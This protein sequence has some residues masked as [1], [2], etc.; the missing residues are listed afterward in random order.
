M[1]VEQ[2]IRERAY[3][4]WTADGC[5]P[6]NADVHWFEARQIL[7]RSI[8]AHDAALKAEKVGHKSAAWR[9]SRPAPF[10]SAE[11]KRQHWALP[12]RYT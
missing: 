11:Q 3:H 9:S 8:T 5:Q 4:L 2:T 12:S 7:A 1:T 10:Q 6:G